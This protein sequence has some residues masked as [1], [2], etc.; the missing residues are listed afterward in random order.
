MRAGRIWFAICMMPL[1]LAGLSVATAQSPPVQTTASQAAA[2][3]VQ[4]AV[5]PDPV[6]CPVVNVDLG[7]RPEHVQGE[8]AWNACERWVWSCIREG[9]EANLFAKRC[10]E[11][12]VP[13]TAAL[14]RQQR[15]AAFVEPDRYRDTNRLNGAFLRGLLFH[16]EYSER[17]QPAGIRIYGGYFSDIVNLENVTTDRNLVL[18]GSMIRNE[19]RLTNFRTSANFSLDGSNVRG[20]LLL[21]RA[22]IDG[23]LFLQK[24]VYDHLDLRDARIG[25][26][27]DAADSTFTGLVRLDRA[28]IAGKVDFERSRLTNWSAVDASIGGL[29]RMHLV[30]VRARLDLTGAKIGGDVRMQKIRFGRWHEDAKPLC[31]WDLDRDPKITFSVEAT[32]FKDRPDLLAKMRTEMHADRPAG[33]RLADVDASYMCADKIQ[34]DRHELLLREMKIGGTLCVIDVTGA[35]E[36]M[37]KAQ[38]N[39]GGANVIGLSPSSLDQPS[40]ETISLD[41]TEAKSTVLRWTESDSTTLWHAVNFSTGHML[42]DMDSQP[43]RH[44]IDN[45]D[46]KTLAFVSSKVNSSAIDKVTEESDKALCDISPDPKTVIPADSRAAHDRIIS[47][48]TTETQHLSRSAQPFTKIV[49]RLQTSGSASTH[50]KM[51]LSE[52]KFRQLCATSE[53]LKAWRKEP[54]TAWYRAPGSL[55]WT[56]RSII[57][58]PDMSSLG[59]KVDEVRKMTLDA[60]CVG[61]VMSYKYAVSYGHEPHN[62]VFVIAI[63]VLL[64]WLLL[65]FDKSGRRA[66]EQQAS[67]TLGL[68]YSIDMFNPFPQVQ[69]NK[70]H[71][72]LHPKGR[73]LKIYL[74]FHRF[75]GFILCLLLAVSIYSAGR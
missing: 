12:R 11:P 68:L 13:E 4:D 63:F 42:I 8:A 6:V 64:F 28:S 50:L 54:A 46:I 2:P 53:V 44:F 52:Y 41:G 47:F 1:V 39:A 24:G 74:R 60:G 22:R 71:A 36:P 59:A 58:Q 65:S 73:G 26:S 14:V 20:V 67:P 33:R 16:K 21:N 19:I 57:G 15:Y 62:I 31:D 45:L 48:F 7:L 30:D 72:T 27:I 17:I 40:I 38:V 61:A 18:D 43:R 5:I 66:A 25:A 56:F 69:L 51:G 37:R 3:Q 9:K 23:S 10:L 34:R 75:I 70:E 55:W 35:I 29:L 49:E 32:G